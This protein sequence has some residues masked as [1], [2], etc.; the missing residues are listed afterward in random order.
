MLTKFNRWFIPEIVMMNAAFQLSSLV[1]SSLGWFFGF[2]MPLGLA[3]AIN[4]VAAVGAY[5]FTFFA[6]LFMVSNDWKYSYRNWVRPHTATSIPFDQMNKTDI[7]AWCCENCRGRWLIA[8]F[9]VMFSDDT[10]ATLFL[11]FK[12]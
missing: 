10:D 12:D 3:I 2:A 1:I 7:T 11:M 4:S 9:D 8:R 6:M 5:I